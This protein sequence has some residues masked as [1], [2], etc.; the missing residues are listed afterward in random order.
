MCVCYFLDLIF[1]MYIFSL[2]L[3]G[4]KKSDSTTSFFFFFWRNK[5]THTKERKKGSNIKTHYNSTQNL[6]LLLVE[7]K[8]KCFFSCSQLK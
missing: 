5:H 3:F 6:T 8:S 4:K 1:F 7:C 2:A